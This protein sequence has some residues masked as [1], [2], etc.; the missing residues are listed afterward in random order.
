MK[1]LPL[2]KKLKEALSDHFDSGGT[3]AE[4]PKELIGITIQDRTKCFEYWKAKNRR[5]AEFLP[6]YTES[7]DRA[8]KGL[9][10]D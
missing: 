9:P 6:A 5:R 4:V 1:N 7:M 8:Y 2:T 10:D 3:V